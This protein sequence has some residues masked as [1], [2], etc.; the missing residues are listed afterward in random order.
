MPTYRKGRHCEFSESPHNFSHV[1]V[2]TSIQTTT[3]RYIPSH[4]TVHFTKTVCDTKQ[5]MYDYEILDMTVAEDES[6]N[7]PEKV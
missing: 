6:E 3:R 2:D 1:R 4:Y 5:K 7:V